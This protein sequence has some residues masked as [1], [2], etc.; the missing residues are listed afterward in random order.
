MDADGVRTIAQLSV[1]QARELVAL[2][3]PSLNLDSLAAMTPEVAR[4]LTEH[5]GGLALKGLTQLDDDVG[6]PEA[7]EGRGG[8]HQR[9]DRDGHHDEDGERDDDDGA[10]HDST[11]RCPARNAAAAACHDDVDTRAED[12]TADNRAMAP[13]T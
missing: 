9:P 11:G 13:S 1:E 8:R 10:V 3:L 4:I 6:G 12:S 7:R 5:E 2:Q